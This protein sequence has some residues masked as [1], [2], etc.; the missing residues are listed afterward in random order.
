MQAT[1]VYY[2]S[3]LFLRNERQEWL[4]VCCCQPKFADEETSKDDNDQGS[5]EIAFQDGLPTTCV[6]DD[7]IQ[8]F[9]NLDDPNGTRVIVEAGPS[10]EDND[11]IVDSGDDSEEESST[12]S[13]ES[14]FETDD[15]E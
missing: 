13:H 4:A 2:L 5:A 12:S 15:S 6:V 14:E 11:F 9:N 8:D 1:Q 3:Y 10:Q 7:A